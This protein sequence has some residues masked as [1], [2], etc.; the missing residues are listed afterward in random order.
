MGHVGNDKDGI[1]KHKRRVAKKKGGRQ[2]KRNYLYQKDPLSLCQELHLS[3][4]AQKRIQM[5]IKPWAII[6]ITLVIA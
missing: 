1:K 3:K 5:E 2:S 6:N 4:K